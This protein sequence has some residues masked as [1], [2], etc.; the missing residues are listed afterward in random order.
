MR[1]TTTQ[2]FCFAWPLS[3]LQLA[4]TRVRIIFH[5]RVIA[6]SWRLM[7]SPALSESSPITLKGKRSRISLISPE[8]GTKPFQARRLARTIPYGNPCSCRSD[9]TAGPS[10]SSLLDGPS[11]ESVSV[12]SNSVV[13]GVIGRV[14]PGA[15][16]NGL[17]GEATQ[18]IRAVYMLKKR[19][20]HRPDGKSIR[21]Y[22]LMWRA[23]RRRPPA[24][25]RGQAQTAAME[26][27]TVGSSAP[28]PGTLVPLRCMPRRGGHPD[29]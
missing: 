23:L 24:P 19:R 13:P 25:Y 2:F 8:Q 7:N 11:F 4:R 28:F 26:N 27:H 20:Y 16:R 29:A 3:F 18:S 22:R 15:T 6:M 10:D 1:R 9:N 5:A 17:V 12:R 21:P 14:R